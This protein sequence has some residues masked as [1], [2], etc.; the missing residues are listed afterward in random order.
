MGFKQNRGGNKVFLSPSHGKLVTKCE[1]GDEDAVSRTLE[2][3]VNKGKVIW[4]QHFPGYEGS[5]DA[6]FIEENE[7]WGD[8]LCIDLEDKTAPKNDKYRRVRI[9]VSLDSSYAMRFIRR[10]DNIDLE[11]PVLFDPYE[12]PNRNKPG[13]Y[14][15]GWNLYQNDEQKPIPQTIEDDEVPEWK[16]L[17]VNKQKVYDKTDCMEFLT[18]HLNQWIEK[19]DLGKKAP[20]RE[21]AEDQEEEEA[22][23]KSF[24]KPKSS[25]SGKPAK[26]D[27]DDVDF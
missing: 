13:K 22:P 26:E 19:N 8:K 12:L 7:E 1:E 10:V 2:K 17:I 11:S 4:E 18:A 14:V 6:V 5:I 16:E 21:A 24:G 23:K 15:T 25:G 9:S 20:T 3:G 27:D